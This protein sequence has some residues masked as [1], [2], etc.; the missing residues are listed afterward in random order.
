MQPKTA[1]AH[2]DGHYEEDTLLASDDLWLAP[3][4]YEVSVQ[5]P[6]HVAGSFSLRVESRD[7]MVVPIRL[8]KKEGPATTEI[9]MGEEGGAELGAVESTT[10]PRPKKFDT[11]LRRKYS[12]APDPV[13]RPAEHDG[14]RGPWPWITAATGLTALGTG[15]VL[16]VKEQSTASYLSYGTGAV[17][18]GVSA[19]LFLRPPAEDDGIVRAS[20]LPGGAMLSW[21]GALSF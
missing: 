18:I 3:G 1:T 21:Q 10:D 20:L 5:A 11:L 12:K 9:D 4:T 6:G 19:Y 13:L 15:V 8:T 17:L 16:T 2:I 14:G 7:R